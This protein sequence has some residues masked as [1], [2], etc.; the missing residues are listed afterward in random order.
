MLHHLGR[1]RRLGLIVG[2]LLLFLLGLAIALAA[3]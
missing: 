2:S 3:I 1:H